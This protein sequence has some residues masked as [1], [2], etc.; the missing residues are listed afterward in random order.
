ML[1][2]RVEIHDF[3]LVEELVIEPADGF[4]VLTGE[5][6]AGKS[7]L[8]DAFDFLSGNRSDRNMVRTG[9][10]E[11]RVEALFQSESN[12]ELL[13]FR[14]LN[15][16]G[17]SY[18]KINGELVTIRTLRDKMKDVLAIHGQN[19][20]QAIFDDSLH[21]EL[22]DAYSGSE[23][24]SLLS[25][26]QEL[27]QDLLLIEEDIARL[28]QSPEQRASR[29]DFLAYQIEEIETA[30]LQVSEE[31][32]L[33]KSAKTMQALQTLAEQLNT[34]LQA[35]SADSEV[36]ALNMI[37]HA[38]RA[39]LEAARYSSK[40]KQLAQDLD[41]IETDLD[42]LV[43]EL[44]RTSDKVSYNPEQVAEIDQRLSLLQRLK[45]KYGKSVEEILEY[46]EEAREEFAFLRDSDRIYEEKLA[47]KELV[48][49][50][51]QECS[52]DLMQVRQDAARSLIKK[53]ILELRSLNMKDVSFD[54]EIQKIP[55][56]G[57]PP[58]DPHR[59]SFMFSA[60]PGEP[61][62]PLINIASG[63]EASRILLAIKTVL[64]DV[65]NVSVLIFDEIDRGVAGETSQ[66]IAEKLQGIGRFRQVLCVTHSAP[67]AAAAKKHL[68]IVKLVDEN[69]TRTKL[70]ELN[71]DARV[72]EIA[73]LLSG[74]TNE[75]ESRN[76]AQSLLES[77]GNL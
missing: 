74:K 39:L 1:L 47:E 77:N 15:S 42:E 30:D 56:R 46:L 54:V 21:R 33:L 27:L 11:A 3:A 18:A 24:D 48:L 76:L 45:D 67:I 75:S 40:C 32:E 8:I 36:S 5:T 14:S 9:C 61:V 41:N 28:G 72:E 19:D 7:I 66:R 65:D 2:L 63:G 37:R 4:T 69:R 73:R 6:G 25:R 57:N 44:N 13:I 52:S 64:A 59:V 60:N 35:L 23:A 29:K 17:R 49:K 50:T 22:V 53:I 26:Y 31:A 68:L 71:D 70:E 58:R 34:S 51:M 43:Y 12:E 38:K 62:K 20:Q 10:D 16:S 55:S